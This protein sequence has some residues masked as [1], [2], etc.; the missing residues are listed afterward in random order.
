MSNDN[1]ND[2]TIQWIFFGLLFF[3]LLSFAVVFV[4]NNNPTAFG[5]SADKFDATSLQ[6]N[7][8]SS[9]NAIDPLLNITSETNPENGYLGSRDSVAVSY[10]LKGSSSGFI[11]STQMFMS[12]VFPGTSGAI[13]ISVFVAI[14]SIASLYFIIKNIRTGQ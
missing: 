11:E 1:L 3:C 14:F 2:F 10:G 5:T 4:A 9:D 7:L 13:I 6:A 8:I 12:W